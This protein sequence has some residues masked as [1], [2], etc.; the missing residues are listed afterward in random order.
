[1]ILQLEETAGAHIDRSSEAA[2]RIADLL[3]ITVEF[4]FNAVQCMAAPGGSAEQLAK[5]YDEEV[6][7]KL[8]GPFDRRF[9]SSRTDLP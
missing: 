6:G 8:T 3:G 4:S 7:R 2:Q 1:M 5:R 9:A